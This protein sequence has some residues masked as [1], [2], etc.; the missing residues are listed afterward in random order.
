MRHSS[1]RA[2][3]ETRVI[4]G[5]TSNGCSPRSCPHEL[6]AAVG[7]AHSAMA[8]VQ[9][10]RRK[11]VSRSTPWPQTG[12]MSHLRP[13]GRSLLKATD[14]CQHR[15][16]VVDGDDFDLLALCL[17]LECPLHL[18]RDVGTWSEDSWIEIAGD[19]AAQTMHRV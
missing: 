11:L 13:R 12:P 19:R 6:T 9:S 4:A 18:P 7:T 17:Q 3:A 15:Q 2:V 10:V 16:E 8:R 5:N 14:I 1:C